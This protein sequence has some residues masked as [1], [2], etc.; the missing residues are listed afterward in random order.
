VTGF[1]TIRIRQININD[2]TTKSRNALGEM[3]LELDSHADI[4]VLG[5]DALIIL[6]TGEVFHLVVNQAIHIPH[7]DHHLLCPMQCHVNDVIVDYLPKNLAADPTDGT[8]AL[9]I[10]DPYDLLQTVILP[11]G[12]NGVFSFLNVRNLSADDYDSGNF[13]RLH[14]TSDTLTWDPMTTI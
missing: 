14:L 4:L 8:H 7:L 10:P 11:L 2:V 5:C 3:T 9:T 13:T 12:L 1:W 6:V